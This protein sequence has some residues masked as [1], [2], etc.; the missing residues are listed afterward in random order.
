MSQYVQAENCE[1]D[2]QCAKTELSQCHVPNEYR[3][4]V[5]LAE[6]PISAQTADKTQ[7]IISKQF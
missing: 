7:S 1:V 3:A 6:S 2:S 5:K 4:H